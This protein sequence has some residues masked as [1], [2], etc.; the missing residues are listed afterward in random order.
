[1]STFVPAG[2]SIYRYLRTNSSLSNQPL[3]DSWN[4]GMPEPEG[5][6]LVSQEAVQ[7]LWGEAEI[8]SPIV[9]ICECLCINGLK[10]Q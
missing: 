8:F 2:Y 9:G 4:R 10:R 7:E 5:V 1:M 6:A 3:I